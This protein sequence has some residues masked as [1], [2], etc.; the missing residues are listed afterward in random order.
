[1]TNPYSAQTLNGQ[2]MD[3][4]VFAGL[5][6]TVEMARA[7][8]PTIPPELAEQARAGVPSIVSRSEKLM[9]GIEDHIDLAGMQRGTVAAVSGGAPNVPAYLSGA[10][11]AMRRRQQVVN[12]D[13]G[14]IVVMVN[15]FAPARMPHDVARRRG[16]AALALVRAAST[17]RPVRLFLFE[18]TDDRVLTIIRIETAPLD[19]AR[20]AWA[21]GELAFTHTTL[22]PIQFRSRFT[23]GIR[24]AADD[25]TEKTLKDWAAGLGAAGVLFTPP[26]LHSH[27]EHFETD[28][29]AARW[30]VRQLATISDFA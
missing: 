20:A 30:T 14:E 27:R 4:A 13:Q 18:L 21:A 1:M 2:E 17:V 10:P 12:S 8:R 16:A 24:C 25:A 22:I 28:E 9:A 26:L 3:V 5:S 11:L 7:I 6:E 15:T 23:G 29:A 19:L